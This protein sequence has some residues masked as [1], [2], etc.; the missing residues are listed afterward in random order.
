MFKKKLEKILPS[1]VFLTMVVGCGTGG[2]GSSTGSSPIVD[3]LAEELSDGTTLTQIGNPHDKPA[4]QKPGN[5]PESEGDAP[6]SGGGSYAPTPAGPSVPEGPVADDD[7]DEPYAMMP[8]QPTFQAGPA[9]RLII[10]L[11]NREGWTGTFEENNDPCPHYRLTFR[12]EKKQAQLSFYRD[13]SASDFCYG[14]RAQYE[15][16][17]EDAMTIS[18][19]SITVVIEPVESCEEIE[20]VVESTPDEPDVTIHKSAK[21]PPLPEMLEPEVL[22]DLEDEEK[23]HDLPGKIAQKQPDLAPRPLKKKPLQKTVR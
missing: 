19:D 20:I 16:D 9:E 10:C 18:F 2:T 17:E 4:P 14:S 8:A 5:E 1:L 15:F 22:E 3:I 7:G 12:S 21:A 11:E 23:T 6:D 13:E